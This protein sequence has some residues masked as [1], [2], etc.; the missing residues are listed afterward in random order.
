MDHSAADDLYDIVRH[1][2]RDNPEA[3]AD[4]AESL[5]DGCGSLEA[6]HAE[7][8]RDGSKALADWF[9]PAFPTLVVYR[10]QD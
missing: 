8:A 7:V 2:Q 6:F 5:Y 1:I 3:A 10:I 4:I 9:S